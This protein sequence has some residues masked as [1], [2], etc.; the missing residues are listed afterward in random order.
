MRPLGL[1]HRLDRLGRV[2]IPKEWRS[3]LGWDANT[4]IEM[5]GS[6]QGIFLRRYDPASRAGLPEDKIDEVAFT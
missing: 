1:V 4:P 5:F 2:T 3:A 6:E